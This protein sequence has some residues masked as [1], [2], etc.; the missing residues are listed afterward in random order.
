MLEWRRPRQTLAERKREAA[1]IFLT[2]LWLAVPCAAAEPV[3]PSKTSSATATEKPPVL[4]TETAVRR[5]LEHMRKAGTSWQAN[6]TC[7][8][9]HHHT[10]SLLA[11]RESRRAGF[12]LDKAWAK[13]LADHAHAYFAGGTDD[14]DEGVHVP[15]GS[16]ER[17]LRPLGLEPRQPADRR[18]DDCDGDLPLESP[19]IGTA[20]RSR[21]VRSHEAQRRALARLMSPSADASLAGRRYRA[22][23]DRPRALAARTNSRNSPRPE[24]QRS[25]G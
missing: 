11:C 16:R 17:R 1:A 21:A 8:A 18:R 22:R 13:S 2:M 25:G 4:D 9:C 15:G 12:P 10:L 23:V 19:R 6:E 14:M 5:G 7:F 3:A 24:Q 20:E